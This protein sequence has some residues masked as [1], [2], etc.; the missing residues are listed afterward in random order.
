MRNASS[1]SVAQDVFNPQYAFIRSSNVN[2]NDRAAAAVTIAST[3]T[4][5]KSAFTRRGRRANGWTFRF[6]ALRI[7]LFL[8]VAGSTDTLTFY[9]PRL[10]RASTATVRLRSQ[11][12]PDRHL[13]LRAG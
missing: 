1:A 9:A 4:R 5:T 2:P 8:S 11:K 13:Q 3:A 10:F 12:L 6:E 7:S